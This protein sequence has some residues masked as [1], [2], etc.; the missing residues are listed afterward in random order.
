[1]VKYTPIITFYVTLHI[2][3]TKILGLDLLYASKFVHI[4]I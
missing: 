4:I 3:S 1:M 2:K